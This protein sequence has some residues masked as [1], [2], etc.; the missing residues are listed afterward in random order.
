ME[1]T[2]KQ[3]RRAAL[4][5][6]AGCL[7]VQLCVGIIYLWSVLKSSVAESLN[8]SP[9]AAGMMASYMLMAFVAGGL[10]GGILT[11]RRGHRFTAMLGVALFAAGIGSGALLTERSAGLLVLTYAVAGGAGSGIAYSACVNCIQKWMP[12]R[13]GLASGLAIG[14]FGLSTVVFVPVMRFIMEAFRTEAGIVNFTGVFALLGG[15]FF[16]VG[17]LGCALIQRP[18]EAAPAKT[19]DMAAHEEMGLVQA[20]RSKKF[21][22]IFFIVFFINGA[23][24][25]ATPMIYDLG[26]ERGLTPELAALA[27]SLTGIANTAGRLLMAVVSDRLGRTQT[28]CLLAVMTAAASLL[29]ISVGGAAYIAAI[30]ALA[31]AFGGPS[32]INAALTTDSFGTKHSAEIYGVVLLALGASSLFF[33]FLS[34]RVLGGS[35]A[36]AFAVG[37]VSAVIPLLLC[38]AMAKENSSSRRPR[39]LM[40]KRPQLQYRH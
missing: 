9:Q 4:R 26:I 39:H 25:L 5:S 13:K 17:M 15:G 36:A 27:L 31:F 22:C 34:S 10:A 33:N 3:I 8:M 28:L 16:I 20:L 1:N 32:S 2:E 21:W 23:W 29:L 18:P 14:A 38:A 6:V 11:D 12:R 7:M 40:L 19:G 35:V 30:C 37:A 24:N